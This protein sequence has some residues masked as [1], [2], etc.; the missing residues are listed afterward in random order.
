MSAQECTRVN[1]QCASIRRY[2]AVR[3]QKLMKR[4]C[5]TSNS[6]SQSRVRIHSGA[7]LLAAAVAEVAIVCAQG[8]TISL[9][10]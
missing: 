10:I 6:V 8:A 4:A 7:V 1:A 2:I 3:V 5:V 9:A